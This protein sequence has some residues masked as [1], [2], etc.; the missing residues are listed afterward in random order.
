[1]RIRKVTII[2]VGLIGG[3]LGLA[4]K[5]RRKAVDITGVTAHKSTLRKA[6]ERGSIDRGTLEVGKSVTG[7]DLVIIATPVDRILSTIRAIIPHLKKD[8]LVMDVGSVKGSIVGRAERLIKGNGTFVGAHPMAGS[9]QRGIGKAG[10]DLF[11]D[12]PCIVTKTK[13]TNKK[14]YGKAVSFWRGLGAS[15]YTFSPEEHDRRIAGV[16]HLPHIAAAALCLVTEPRLLK[17]ASSGYRDTTRIASGDPAIWV[18]ILLS[19]GK[20]ASREIRRYIA[21]LKKIDKAISKNDRALLKSTLEKAKSNKE[22]FDSL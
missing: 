15:V 12:S 19:N 3:S 4:I 7:A 5:K 20:N 2:G 22:F 16:S 14:A 18:P 1:M 6:L 10:A 11:E 9:E 13:D 8:T 17:L 21:A